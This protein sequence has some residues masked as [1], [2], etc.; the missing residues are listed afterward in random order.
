MSQKHEA[1][2][3]QP[4]PTNPVPQPN[5]AEFKVSASDAQGHGVPIQFRVP[6][7]MD[8]QIS[9]IISSK[10]FPYS[11]KGDL[12]R[13]A[14]K[15]HLELLVSISPVRS[16]V[17]QIDAINT[18]V[19]EDQY[20]SDFL[21]SIDKL[22]TVV[23]DHQRAGREQQAISL[24]RRVKSQVETMPDDAVYRELYLKELEA[25]WGALLRTSTGSFGV[26]EEGDDDGSD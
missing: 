12:L 17:Q 6:P 5:A 16:F 8:R 20:Q 22:A 25:R 13:H 2:A 11:T 3:P 14:L 4:V 18:I 10:Y 26:M 21:K 23:L 24:I 1:P 7:G 15:S 9:E 19:T